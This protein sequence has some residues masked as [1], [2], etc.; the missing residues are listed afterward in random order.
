MR[1]HEDE[2]LQL[3][4]RRPDRIKRRIVEVAAV[5]VGA[6]LRAAQTEPAHGA[7]ELVGGALRMLQRQ[8]REPHEALGMAIDDGGDLVVLQRRAGGAERGLLVVEEGVH[9]GA[10]RLHVD[11]VPVHVGEAQVEIPDFGGIGRCTTLPAISMM[12]RHRLARR[13]SAP[14]A[15]IPCRAAGSSPA[16]ACG[17]G[18][19]WCGCGSSDGLHNSTAVEE[20]VTII[21]LP[22]GPRRRSRPRFSLPP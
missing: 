3:V 6:D 19:R 10:H 4:R 1:V 22:R 14:P 7:R 2:R 8:G 18:R 12:S 17:R 21:M 16:A 9:G 11:A 20:G 15:A 13:A 5:D